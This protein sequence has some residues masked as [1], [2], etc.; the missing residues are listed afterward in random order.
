MCSTVDGFVSRGGAGV[1][2]GYGVQDDLDFDV[3]GGCG[4]GAF[5]MVLLLW[6]DMTNITFSCNYSSRLKILLRADEYPRGVE[7]PYQCWFSYFYYGVGWI[8]PDGIP[9]SASFIRLFLF[10]KNPLQLFALKFLA[11][12]QIFYF[13]AMT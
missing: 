7:N 6:L 4:D 10:V 5:E 2:R 3:C 12:Y 1:G 13:T 11:C 9:F 8:K